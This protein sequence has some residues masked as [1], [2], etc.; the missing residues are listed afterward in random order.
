MFNDAPK[1]FRFPLGDI[2]EFFSVI[3]NS[4]CHN[5]FIS[6]YVQPVRLPCIKILA[7]LQISSRTFV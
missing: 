4:V 7:S 3:N 1:Q 2:E 6:P 5:L